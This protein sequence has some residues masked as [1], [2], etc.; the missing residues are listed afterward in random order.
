MFGNERLPNSQLIGA[1]VTVVLVGPTTGTR[2]ARLRGSGGGGSCSRCDRGARSNTLAAVARLTRCPGRV[3]P[4]LATGNRCP[5]VRLV[6]IEIFNRW[7][8][9]VVAYSVIRAV[10]VTWQWRVLLRVGKLVVHPLLMLSCLSP[11]EV[12]REGR[13]GEPVVCVGRLNETL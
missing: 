6:R 3:A 11:F 2:R 7:R 1:V 10:E 13:C 9:G 8:G 12:V 4:T 5:A